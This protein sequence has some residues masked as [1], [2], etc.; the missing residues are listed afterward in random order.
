MSGAPAVRVGACGMGTFAN[1]SPPRETRERLNRRASLT[2]TIAAPPLRLA[3]VIPAKAGIQRIAAK[4][5]IR[6]QV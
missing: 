3:R 1:F 2:G 4:P 5:A 6:N